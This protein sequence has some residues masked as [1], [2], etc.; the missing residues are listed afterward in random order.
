MQNLP[1]LSQAL[2]L[3]SFKPCILAGLL[4]YSKIKRL[5]NFSVAEIL[6]NFF[7]LNC[8]FSIE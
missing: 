4:T 7:N 1:C 6:S 2:F 5:P 3:E 8:Q